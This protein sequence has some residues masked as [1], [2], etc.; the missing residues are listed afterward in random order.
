MSSRII[1]TIG[2][3]LIFLNSCGIRDNYNQM[4]HQ[5]FLQTHKFNVGQSTIELID[6]K[7]ERPVKTEIWYP[8]KDTTKQNITTEYPFKLPPTSCS[9]MEQVAIE[10]AKC[11]LP[12]N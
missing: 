2:I 10:L 12:V 5:E 1:T 3:A 11:G 6:H 4:S 7:R 9:P 8:T